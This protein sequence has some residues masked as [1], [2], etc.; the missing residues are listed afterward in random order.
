[1]PATII[2]S[3]H[4]TPMQIGAL[5]A[6]SSGMVPLCSVAAGVIADRSR[7]RPL[8][9]GTNV[10]RLL[11]LLLIPLA[12][13]AGHAALWLFFAVAAVMA[14]ASAIFDAAY[15]AFVPQVVGEANIAPA[16]S[17]LA[18]GSSL[19]EAAGNGVAGMLVMAVGA[20]L[21]VLVNV[22]T[23]V[24]ATIS[25]LAIRVTEPANVHPRAAT[26]L[27]EDLRAGVR[28]V[29]GHPLLRR[30]TL[31][32]A[33]A[34]FG[35]GMAAAVTTVYVYRELHLPPLVLGIVIGSANLGALAAWHADAIARRFGMR[36][37]M[38]AAHLASAAGKAMLPLFAGMFPVVALLVSR[39]LLTASGPVF[40]V[41]DASLRL[42]LT[43][44]DLRARAT[45][46]ARTI[47]WGALPL[48]SLAG[49]YLG[50]HAGL[51]TTMLIGA[52]ITAS[53]ALVLRSSAGVPSI[54]DEVFR[55]A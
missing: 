12:F 9:I 13:A 31:S 38:A 42:S 43:P 28:V 24:Y 10:V 7:R 26:S 36:R 40:A 41:N 1:L 6:L 48:G 33:V 14:A 21:V 19:A 11:A 30:V 22:G 39:M 29:L 32:N 46:T 17:K 37:A 8:L 52:S 27:C 3:M 2:L 35:G 50:G 34:H 25:I 5:D 53:A 23:F 4:A 15:A 49:G 47:V 18:M 20:P 54:G 45:A 16:T 44:D 51:A 55:I